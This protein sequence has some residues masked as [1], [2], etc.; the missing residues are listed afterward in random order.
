MTSRALRFAAGLPL[1][2]LLA[3]PASAE[4]APAQEPLSGRVVE[5]AASEYAFRSPDTIPAGLT[6]FRLRQEGRVRNGANLSPA[7][8]DSL[9]LHEGDPTDGMH[10]L[11]L[12][13]LDPGKTAADLYAAQRADAPAPWAHVIGGP[14]FAF[15]PRSTNATLRLEPGQYVLVCYVGAARE[16]RRR[17]HLLKGM[18]R[19]LTVSPSD[20]PAAPMPEPDVVVTFGAGRSVAFSRPIT[21][22]GAWKVLV[23]NATD[24]R[25]VFDIRRILPGHTAA[26]AASW[27]RADGKPPVSEVWGGLAGVAAGDAMLTTIDFV[28]GTYVARG[29]TFVVAE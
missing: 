19:P 7:G 27:R 15:P 23:R 16:D 8:R 24:R 20:A 5:V 25:G 4:P 1:L 6:T 2:A 21:K 9:A 18:F 11:W 28:P 10:M 17:Y 3:V 13:R 26:E 12:V 14:G 22:A 29:T